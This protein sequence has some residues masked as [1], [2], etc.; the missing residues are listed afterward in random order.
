MVRVFKNLFGDGSKIDADEIAV[1]EDILLRDILNMLDTE[2]FH[3]NNG[4]CIRYGSGLQICWHTL[5]MGFNEVSAGINAFTWSFPMPFLDTSY[6]YDF[7]VGSSNITVMNRI[8]Y[9]GTERRQN[10][11][12]HQTEGLLELSANLSSAISISHFAIGMWK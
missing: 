5:A 6:F 9:V 10:R 11:T 4:T 1:G 7:N 8:S 3:N 12:T 2:I